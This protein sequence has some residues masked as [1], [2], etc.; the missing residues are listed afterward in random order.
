METHETLCKEGYLVGFRRHVGFGHEMRRWER[1]GLW[2]FTRSSE[3]YEI[4]ETHGP[5]LRSEEFGEW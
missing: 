1:T 2:A 4:E 3:L 5:S